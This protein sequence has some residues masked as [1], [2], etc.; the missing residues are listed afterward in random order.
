MCLGIQMVMPSGLPDGLMLHDV[1]AHTF[2]KAWHIWESGDINLHEG[3]W[4]A[5]PHWLSKFVL[6]GGLLRVLRKF[7]VSFLPWKSQKMFPLCNNFCRC[8]WDGVKIYLDFFIVFILLDIEGLVII[9]SLVYCKLKSLDTMLHST[10]VET[11]TL[12]GVTVSSQ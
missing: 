10:L 4:G 1:H 12:T 6:M 8:P 3:Q 11:F 9:P 2:T 5:C 7:L